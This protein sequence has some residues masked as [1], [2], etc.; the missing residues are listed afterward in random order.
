LPLANWRLPIERAVE[1]PQSA[2]A[3]LKSAICAGG[4][5]LEAKNLH[6]SVD[7]NEIL[8][9]INLKVNAG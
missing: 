2:I 5:M 3:N 4:I 9:G 6:A 1:I 7:K 8:R